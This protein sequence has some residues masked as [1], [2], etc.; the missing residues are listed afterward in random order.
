MLA[1]AAGVS[2]NSLSVDG[3]VS[4]IFGSA[5][6]QSPASFAV[7]KHVWG[8]QLRAS[9]DYYFSEYFSLQCKVEG[10]LIPSVNVPAVSHT[11]PVDHEAKTL[12]P[13]SIDFSGLG[14]SLGVRCHV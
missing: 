10:K 14:F 5:Y 12:M 11:N 1:I 13:H 8:L 6:A 7:N 9:Y 2:Y 3:T 4:S